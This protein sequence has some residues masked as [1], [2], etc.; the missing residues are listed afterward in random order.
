MEGLGLLADGKG[1]RVL[2]KTG[3]A[4]EAVFAVVA[5]DFTIRVYCYA[6]GPWK[7]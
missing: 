5:A 3:D 7:A 4:P 1:Y 6:H 2:R